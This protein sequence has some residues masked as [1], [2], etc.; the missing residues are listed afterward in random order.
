MKKKKTV[1]TIILGVVLLGVLYA[2]YL[3]AFFAV[4]AVDSQKT[5]EKML[6]WQNERLKSLKSGYEQGVFEKID[7]TS[8]CADDVTDETKLNELRFLGTHNSYKNGIEKTAKNFF[9]YALFTEKYDYALPTVTEQLNQGIRAFEIDVGKVVRDGKTT[10]ESSHKYFSDNK[11]SITDT[12]KGFSEIKMWSDYNKGHLPV[13]LQIEI[14]NKGITANKYDTTAEDIYVFESKVKEIMGETLFT[15]KDALDGNEDFET[16][17]KKDAY[18]KLNKLRG[19]IIVFLQFDKR[20]RVYL[21]NDNGFSGA[22]FVANDSAN[23]E[24]YANKTLFVLVNDSTDEESIKKYVS[25]NYIIRT[26]LD[27]YGKGGFSAATYVKGIASGANIL[28]TDYPFFSSK[29]DDYKVILAG[30]RTVT[31]IER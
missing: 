14:K 13:I 4:T 27:K 30:N 25:D 2:V 24:K 16:L 7:E 17:R 20:S 11:S 19:K 15:P 29:R 28:S 26:R 31:R 3:G 8:I 12:L 1:A 21:E 6:T 5:R 23:P 18:P 22:F 10:F 9:N